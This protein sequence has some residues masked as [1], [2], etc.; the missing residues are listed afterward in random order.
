MSRLLPELRQSTLVLERLL[1]HCRG[2]SYRKHSVIIESGTAPESLHYLVRGSVR[3][4][5][6]DDGQEMVLDYLNS[7][8]FFGFGE[9][10]LFQDEVCSAAVVARED[11]ETAEIPYDRFRNLIRQDPE[12]LMLLT[13]RVT[14][15]LRRTSEKVVSMVFVDVTGRI[16]RTLLELA[17]QPD[18][19]THPAGMQLH[20]TRQEIA[21]LVGCSREMAGR[22]LK[23]LEARGLISAHGKTI[24]V[25]GTR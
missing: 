14:E 2:R 1:P 11:T 10:G 3:V 13:G 17:R 16:A 24:I 4:T 23:D 20:I 19:I 22:V 15:R 8:E 6:R 7:G 5:V 18:A 25:F 21:K 9:L 12:I